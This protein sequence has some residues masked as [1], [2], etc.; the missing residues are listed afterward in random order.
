MEDPMQDAHARSAG[1]ASTS[2][3]ASSNAS[4]SGASKSIVVLVIGA[5]HQPSQQPYNS[6]AALSSA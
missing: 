1:E 5:C 2:A 3:A 6:S 4:P